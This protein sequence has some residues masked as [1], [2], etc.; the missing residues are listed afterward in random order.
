MNPYP[1]YR[2]SGVEWLGDVPEHWGVLPT[3]HASRIVMGQSPPS[4]TYQDKPVE[5]PFLQGNAEFGP[6]SPTPKWYCNA[7]PKVVG[8]GALLL[9][10]RAPVGALNVA[11]Q[12]LGIGRGLCGI[13]PD[14]PHVDQRFAW[15]A[16]HVTRRALEPIAVGSTYD[17]V[18][19]EQVG[20]L[21]IPLPPLDEQRAI[22]EYLDR[23]TERIDALVAKM[24]LLIE[25]LQEY[26]TALIT[27][28]V[29]RGLP[30][31]AARA[32]GLDPSPRL[33]PSGVEWLGDVPEH[34]EVGNIQRYAEM[35]S[36]H[37]PSRQHL[38]YW[39][40]CDIPW[41]TLSDVWQLRDGRAT[42][43]YKTCE[44]ISHVGIANSAAELLPAGSVILSRTASIGF[45]GIM[46]VPMATSQDFWNWVCGPKLTPKYLLLTFRS[47]HSEFNRLMRGSTHRTIYEASAASFCGSS[48]FRVDEGAGGRG[49]RGSEA[50]VEPCVTRTCTRG[51]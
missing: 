11:D 14:P 31:D 35:K 44:L 50:T 7:A 47:M 39:E 37:T 40:D 1:V 23:E 24:R 26:R 3:K 25:R 30:P 34:W 27:R 10:V 16:L 42:Y 4:D 45:S 20:V 51:F 48:G 15:W 6:Y 19:A 29:T 22:A 12:T 33:K 9:S 46:P 8:A 17:A 28:T 43:L 49:V 32:A 18:S 36:G 21:P 5:R 38:D 13:V 2:P 41:F